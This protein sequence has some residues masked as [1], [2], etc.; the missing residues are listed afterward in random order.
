MSSSCS[1]HPVE[2]SLHFGSS[3]KRVATMSSRCKACL[4][5]RY[6][7]R[8]RVRS[9]LRGRRFLFQNLAQGHCREMLFRAQH[10]PKGTATVRL[11]LDLVPARSREL[12]VVLSGDCPRSEPFLRTYVRVQASVSFRHTTDDEYMSCIN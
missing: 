5:F 9:S 2:L 10:I 1:R 8:R 3:A 6:L 7:R 11:L 12:S 4:Q